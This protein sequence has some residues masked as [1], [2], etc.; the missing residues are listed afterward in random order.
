[1]RDIYPK[2]SLILN[3]C[4]MSPD[5]SECAQNPFKCVSKLSESALKL[6]CF[7]R[8]HVEFCQLPLQSKD[9]MLHLCALKTATPQAGSIY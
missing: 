7:S 9:N 2:N 5:E 6:R 1:M 3:D 8:V 4:F